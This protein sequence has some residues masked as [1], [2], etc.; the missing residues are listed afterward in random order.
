MTQNT[1]LAKKPGLSGQGYVL[2]HILAC[3]G[4]RA[5]SGWLRCMMH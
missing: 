4:T 1:V 5:G 2:Y 3:L